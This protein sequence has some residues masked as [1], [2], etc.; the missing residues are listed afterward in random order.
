MRPPGWR[1]AAASVRGAAHEKTGL[2]CQDAHHWC[3]LSETVLLVAV[4]DGAGSAPLAEIGASK[5]VRAAVDS[6]QR[7]LGMA[8]APSRMAEVDWASLLTATLIEA[9]AAVEAEANHRSLPPAD[10]AS[11]LIVAIAGLDFVAAVQI[12]DGAVIA[13]ESSG[14][15]TCV[16]RPPAGEYLNETTFL[17]SASA[18]DSARPIVW[19]GTLKH[20][21]VISDGLQMAALKMPAAEPHPG[22][23]KP[24]FGFLEQQA[25]LPEAQSA[26]ASFLASP[27]LRERTDD[28]ITLLL[29]TL[30]A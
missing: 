2:P 1:V 19:R 13:A 26:L 27:R 17:T 23:F 6:V 3:A 16:T 20:L 9:K 5:A 30:L 21:A 29:G 12:G 24:L 4:A 22:F 14:S 15:L 7:K 25:D 18:L 28:D 10:F 11:T 8:P